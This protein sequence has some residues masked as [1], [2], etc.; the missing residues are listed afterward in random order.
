M[1]SLNLTNEEADA[2]LELLQY[3]HSELRMEIAST[4]SG[5][6]R[7]QLKEKK[8]MLK[9]IREQ[10]IELQSHELDEAA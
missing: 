8:V 3:Q 9:G 10:L 1:I 2:L 4:D 6:F 7:S 5:S